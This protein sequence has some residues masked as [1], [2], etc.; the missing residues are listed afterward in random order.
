MS[1][2][3]RTV[4][5]L[6][7]LLI[8]GALL[9]CT[10]AVPP[11]A[12]QGAGGV[13]LNVQD[14]GASGSEFETTAT[15][16]EG[17]NQI[18]VKAPG[19]FKVGHGVMVSR[20]NIRTS[21]MRYGPGSPYGSSRPIKDEL[22]FRGYDG[23]A[24]G[25]LVYILEI[26]GAGPP[27]FRWTDDLARTWKG[28]KVPITFDWQTLSNGI[29]VKFAQQD[30]QPGHMISYTM[31]DQL[32][33]TI[34]KIEGNVFTLSRPANRAASDAVVRHNDQGALQAAIDRAVR[35][36]RNVYFP[37]GHYRLSGSLA[38]RNAS[39]TIEGQ[40]GVD[41]LLDISDGSGSCF[42]LQGGTDVTVRNFKMIGHTGFNEAAGSF[43]TSSG[44]GFW[45]CALKSCNAVSIT[46]TERTLIENVHAS[47]MASEAFYAQAGCRSSTKEPTQYQ[48][49]LIY[50]R[51]SVT[52]CAANAF[53]NNDMGENTSVLYCRIDGANWH[54]AEMP[55]RF[56]K[57]VGNYVRN[58]GAFT[59][60]DMSHRLDDLHKL[61][62]GQA[63]VVDNVFEGIGRCG[64]ISVNHGSG[65][66]VIANNLFINYNG[67]AINASSQCVRTS[68][69]SHTVTIT[70][71]IIDMTYAGEKPAGRTGINVSAN[72]VIVS[73]NQIYVRGKLDP[74]VNG[75]AIAEPALNVS[76]HGNLIR[77]C[78]Y[79]LRTSRAA[80]RVT[81]VIDATT[82]V[83]NGLPLEWKDSHRYRDWNLVWVTGS[84]P[85]TL[86]VIE[87]FDPETL[88]FKLRAPAEMKVGDRF[89]V[90]PPGGANWNIHHNT[91]AGCL[92][93]VSLDSAGSPTSA[94]TSNTVTNDAVAGLKQAVDVRGRFT[95][96][97]NQFVGFDDPASCVLA[98]RPDR[99]GKPI[100]NQY[101]GNVFERCAN[102]VSESEK[103]LWDATEAHGNVF[104]EC[105]GAPQAATGAETARDQV[106]PVLV[107]APA[108]RVLRATPLTTP[109][110][111]DGAVEEW[112]W[113]ETARVVPL[114][115][116]PAGDPVGGATPV[117][118]AAR[119]D[120]SWYLALRLPIRKG[121]KLRVGGGPYQGDGLELAFQNTDPQAPSPIY[122]LWGG[123]DGKF[124]TVSAGGTTAAQQE[125]ARKGITYAVRVGETEWTCEWRIPFAA[126][127]MNPAIT[128]RLM[129][130][131]GALESA[132]GAW[133]A[134]FATGGALYEVGG[135]G[136]LL[137]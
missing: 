20:C 84:K 62:C 124:D 130:N 96:I 102:V 58:A 132:S 115:K 64:G 9:L 92:N 40:S 25:W 37:A 29:D 31:R 45:A 17:S 4:S 32:V 6:A 38:V 103:G 22:E 90:F 100:R 122:V 105:K 125:R 86:A 15:T 70:G 26:D 99:L 131:V 47:R 127:E 68:F 60:G 71:N 104:I 76:V 133:T 74:L 119:D 91:I 75:I 10:A 98:L 41:T 134:C 83:E 46:G 109:V 78:N 65:Q 59:I 49:S 1:A 55:A 108:R 79:G 36:K 106:T 48:K 107:A 53:N 81:E 35:E 11:A 44:F 111:V 73:N 95:F 24:G 13:W 126:V 89:E 135:A 66:V 43:T 72:N 12:A 69:P 34:T 88:R 77:N 57:L 93:P 52:D 56:L 117:V 110:T 129:F 85:N 80:S 87:A 16:A 33:A 50:L 121:A 39:I 42:G 27:T 3:P 28:R 97:G 21:G 123:A 18:T 128:K 14:C 61:G 54:A 19:D 2:Q 7:W 82:F 51:C 114:D 23:K 113:T 137:L 136:D 5:Q 101:R 63:I 116:T 112:P 120:A 8:P 118:L 94:F 67:T 30:W